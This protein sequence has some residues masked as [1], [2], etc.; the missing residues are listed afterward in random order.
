MDH[1]ATKHA[2][3]SDDVLRIAIIRIWRARARG[4]LLERLRD[5]AL[6]K[7]A[8]TVWSGKLRQNREREQKAVAFASRVTSPAA[9]TA[10][11]HWTTRLTVNRQ[12]SLLAQQYHAAQTQYKALYTWRIALRAHLKRARQARHAERFFVLRRAMGVWQTQMKERERER[13]LQDW[14]RAKVRKAWELWRTKASKAAQLRQ[15]EAVVVRRVMEREAREALSAWTARVISVK[16]RELDVAMRADA[17]VLSHVMGKWKALCGRHVEMLNLMES[18][19]SVKQDGRFLVSSIRTRLGTN[20][21]PSQNASV[22]P[23]MRGVPAPVAHTSSAMPRTSIVG[24][25]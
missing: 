4:R 16:E 15:A 10:L 18:Y 12:S 21:S 25:C 13:R 19:R 3:R 2:G 1:K 20:T 23:F 22:R 7:R 9:R 11:M 17:K 24:A 8:L 5:A 6:L 14:H